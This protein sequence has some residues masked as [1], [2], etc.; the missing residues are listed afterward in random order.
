[1]LSHWMI[2]LLNAVF[3]FSLGTV[4]LWLLCG[5]LISDRVRRSSPLKRAELF[6]SVNRDNTPFL[7][8]P[9]KK[10]HYLIGRGPECDHVGH[11]P[12]LAF[13]VSRGIRS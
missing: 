2:K 3:V 10:S 13:T 9:L 11:S 1:M 5:S 7:N 6:L 8:I 4:T 12:S